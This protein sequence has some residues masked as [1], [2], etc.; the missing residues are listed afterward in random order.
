MELKRNGTQASAQGPDENFTGK[1][2]IDP[3]NTAPEPARVS[4]FRLT[5]EAND[6]GMVSEAQ[7]V[8]EAE[9]HQCSSGR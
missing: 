7:K 5:N 2:R 8:T 3:L 4:W 9:C 1:V 6:R